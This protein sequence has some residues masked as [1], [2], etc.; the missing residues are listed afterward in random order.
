MPKTP[1]PIMTTPVS[2]RALWEAIFR[3]QREQLDIQ[4]ELVLVLRD[5]D[6]LQAKRTEEAAHRAV[7]NLLIDGAAPDVEAGATEI[8]DLP[9]QPK[10][11]LRPLPSDP[12]I[13][14]APLPLPP[15]PPAPEPPKP[16][17]EAIAK[18][19][20][21]RLGEIAQVIAGVLLTLLG[22]LVRECSAHNH[23]E[24]P[25]HYEANE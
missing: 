14:P 1:P 12:K 25:A 7:I 5:A 21:R 10:P 8:T 9:P 24:Q 23:H 22:A 11:R 4:R 6:S 3:N 2:D 16:D 17:P 15:P 20:R 13:D 18:D 19:R